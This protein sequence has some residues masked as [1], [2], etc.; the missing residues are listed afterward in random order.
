MKSLFCCFCPSADL[1][2]HCFLPFQLAQSSKKVLPSVPTMD[3]TPARSGRSSRYILEETP[4]KVAKATKR[5]QTDPDVDVDV[6]EL[7]RGFPPTKPEAKPEAKE[8]AE[9]M[10]GAKSVDEILE[11]TIQEGPEEPTFQMDGKTYRVLDM[12]ALLEVGTI[13]STSKRMSFAEFKRH[14]AQSKKAEA[15]ASEMS[16]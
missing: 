12:P 10:E 11:L 5:S 13:C 6:K 8:S 9:D 7:P 15:V 1:E 14:R 4:G 16:E 3:Q 2:T